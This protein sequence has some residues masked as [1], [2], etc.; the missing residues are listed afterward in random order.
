[1]ARETESTCGLQ[2]EIKIP[3]CDNLSNIQTPTIRLLSV[4]S[5]VLPSLQLSPQ[6]FLQYHMSE[7]S[8]STAGEIIHLARQR[9][10]AKAANTL[11][12]EIRNKQIEEADHRLL[13]VSM[14]C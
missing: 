5:F 14:K 8:Q 9:D 4:L 13:L 12:S 11:E 3:Q 6:Q 2:V 10:F 7:I 1:M